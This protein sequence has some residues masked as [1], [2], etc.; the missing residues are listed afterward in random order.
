M[1]WRDTTKKG[2]DLFKI[3][4]IKLNGWPARQVRSTFSSPAFP[5]ILSCWMFSGCTHW[6]YRFCYYQT[7]P[8]LT[9][10][11]MQMREIFD[12][13]VDRLIPSKIPWLFKAKVKNWLVYK[14]CSHYWF[15]IQLIFNRRV[16][17]TL[18]ELDSHG[19]P[20]GPQRDP[21]YPYH[22]SHLSSRARWEGLGKGSCSASHRTLVCQ[23]ARP[24]TRLG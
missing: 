6:I 2:F 17:A 13:G 19:G 11:A 23:Q 8:Q 3:S 15:P 1:N 18:W 5:H 16:A 4:F 7:E 20:S 14:S 10:G 12:L 24:S 22:S 21:R 9:I